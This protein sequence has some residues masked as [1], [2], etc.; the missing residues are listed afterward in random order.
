M[1][2]VQLKKILID[3]QSPFVKNLNS[4]LVDSPVN[5][6][7]KS[8]YP[9][10][11]KTFHVDHNILQDCR[12]KLHTTNSHAQRN[13]ERCHLAVSELNLQECNPKCPHNHCKGA[14]SKQNCVTL[15]FGYHTVQMAPWKSSFLCYL[16]LIL[17]VSGNNKHLV[18]QV[19]MPLVL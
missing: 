15:H 9:H 4:F 17:R 5:M 11:Q 12:R 8:Q 13:S 19:W 6:A 18:W 2:K 3:S 14:K 16:K 1:L 7:D 10:V